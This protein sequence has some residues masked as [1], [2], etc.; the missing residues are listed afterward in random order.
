MATHPGDIFFLTLVTKIE[1]EY[2]ALE[3]ISIIADRW[4]TGKFLNKDRL[5]DATNFE[6]QSLI[7]SKISTKINQVITTR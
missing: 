5:I 2:R 6:D 7:S 1:L 4:Q 3:L